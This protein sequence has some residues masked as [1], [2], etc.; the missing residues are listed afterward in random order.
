MYSQK[1]LLTVGGTS[2]SN[3]IIHIDFNEIQQATAVYIPSINE[4]ILNNMAHKTLGMKEN[5]KIDLDAWNII[6]PYFE[7]RIRSI[8]QQENVIDQNMHV[9]L[10]NSK[11]VIMNYSIT[12]F[13]SSQY[14]NISMIH[15]SLASEK[16]SVASISSLYTIREDVA[17]LKPYLNRTGII[18][19]EETMKKYFLKG[20]NQNLTFNDQ[21]YYEKELNIIQK[22]YSSLSFRET[23]LCGLLVNDL[24][25]QD[26][27]A[28]TKRTLDAVF[29]AIHR[30]NKKLNFKNKRQLIA[31][32]KEL[33][34]N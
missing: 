21:I 11:Q 30:I 31:S 8:S 15:F 9:V 26:I 27:A 33:T 7:D 3:E 13:K 14:S 20:M 24:E 29:V 2:Q 32:L 4:L 17:K 6:N 28:I 34:K 18:M 23:I 16:Y 19:H 5:E 1:L 10:F 22:A 12:H 25:M